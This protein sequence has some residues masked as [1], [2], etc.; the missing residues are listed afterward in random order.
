MQELSAESG[1]RYFAGRELCL[2]KVI[3]QSSLL[4][5]LA[6]GSL[7]VALLDVSGG[8]GVLIEPGVR[9]I[10]FYVGGGVTG[11]KLRCQRAVDLGFKFARIEI[12]GGNAELLRGIR[13]G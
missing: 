5:C 1:I 2:G 8:E 12:G 4:H 10:E 9:V 13:Q 3:A 11:R 6:D 7:R